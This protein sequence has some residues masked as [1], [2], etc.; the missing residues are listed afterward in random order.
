MRAVL[1]LT[2]RAPWRRPPRVEGDGGAGLVQALAVLAFAVTTAFTLSVLGGL[3][4]FR[5]R[6]DHPA[7]ATVADL[8]PTYVVLAWIAVVLLVVPLLSLGG[9][10]ARLG[11]ARRD[12]RLATLRLLGMTPREVVGLTVVETAAQGLVGAVLGVGGYG[13]LMPVWTRL[14]FLGSP[15]RVD[16]LWV[17]LPMLLAVVAAVPVAAAASGA[18]SLRRVVVSPLGVARR[19]T[20]PGL[21][22]VRALAVVVSVGAFVAVAQGVG[23]FG[24]AVAIGVLL[25]L[26]GVVFGTLALV[27]PWLVG[28]LGKVMAAL[29]RRPATLLAARRLV[30]DPKASWRVVGGLALASFTAGVVSVVP[31]MA[32]GSAGGTDPADAQ[33][34]MLLDD[35]LTGAML[36]LAIAF[37]VAATSAGITQAAAVLDRRREYALQ[38]L[39]GVPTELFDAARRREVLGPLLLVSVTSALVGLVL[40]VP[41]VGL[42]GATDP[43]GILVLVACLGAGLLL[44]VGATETSRPLLRSVLRETVVRAD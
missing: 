39:A 10:A 24:V 2:W 18:A 25:V 9:A 4:A 33:G 5:L 34:A 42:T 17:G 15:L 7:D 41:I 38:R 22:W 30:D 11:V 27:G 16:E 21:R 26:L 29:A 20:P 3:Q 1:R 40:L 13:L 37:V 44:M 43:T 31:A 28:L 35:L 36:T 12:A 6:A 8:A 32:S 23:G 19:V 14:T